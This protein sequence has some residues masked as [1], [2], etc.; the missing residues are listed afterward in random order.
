MD[1][2]IDHRATALKFLLAEN[3][4]VRD[5]AAAEGLAF[6]EHDVADVTSGLCTRKH[7]ANRMITILEADGELA[8]VGLRGIDHLLA[9]GGIHGHRFFRDGVAA[10]F[11]GG[12]DGGAVDTVRR[13]DVDHVRLDFA[14]E[15][16]PFFIAGLDAPLVFHDFQAVRLDIAAADDFDLRN[17]L[18]GAHV[19]LADAAAADDGP[20]EL[21][22]DFF[23]LFDFEGLGDDGTVF[24]HGCLLFGGG[25]NWNGIKICRNIMPKKQKKSGSMAHLPCLSWFMHSF[26]PLKRFFMNWKK[27]V[28]LLHYVYKVIENHEKS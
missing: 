5:A 2:D 4:P 21:F 16:V 7:L 27:H 8:V 18:D 15:V 3:A 19:G 17:F 20:A 26:Y 6:D 11:N 24:G 1:A 25:D 13:A 28:V 14:E 22:V 10:S 12:D 23:F 9:F